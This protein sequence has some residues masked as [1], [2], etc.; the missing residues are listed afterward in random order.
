[1]SKRL[2]ERVEE[3]NRRKVSDRPRPPMV[4]ESTP[5]SRA[6]SASGKKISS[7]EAHKDREANERRQD[8]KRLLEGARK[9]R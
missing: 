1:M 6:I 3:L 9:S 7:S 4:Q 5:V 2:L 8:A